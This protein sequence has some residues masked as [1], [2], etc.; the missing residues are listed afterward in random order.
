M[1][2][3]IKTGILSLCTHYLYGKLTNYIMYDKFVN[4]MY[5]KF[6]NFYNNFFKS[7]TYHNFHL[8]NSAKDS[9]PTIYRN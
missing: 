6:V 3:L 4:F 2:A 8:I 7:H 1:L 5:D 9:T